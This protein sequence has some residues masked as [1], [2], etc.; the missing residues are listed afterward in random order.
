M[1]GS[2]SPEALAVELAAS[3]WRELGVP[4][5][6]RRHERWLITPEPLI[7]YTAALGERDRRLRD[8]ALGWCVAHLPLISTRALRN[9]HNQGRWRVAVTADFATT[10]KALTGARW[11]GHAVGGV[12]TTEAPHQGD[13]A[14]FEEPS[15]LALRLRAMFGVSV[16]TEVLR[17]LLS[18][19]KTRR[20]LDSLPHA[21][22][23]TGRQAAEAV[24]QLSWGGLVRLDRTVQPARLRLARR[25]ALQRLV[26]PLPAVAVDL[27][28]LL[29]LALMAVEVLDQI[30]ATPADL[31]GRHLH[32]VLEEHTDQLAQ[33]GLVPPGLQPATTYVSRTRRWL[34]EFLQSLSA[35]RPPG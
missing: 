3:L 23:A 35:G 21:A 28:A 32:R 29:P 27:G 34:R 30:S 11:P 24:E 19:D 18:A 14:P 31:A 5:P 10:M 4:G 25:E 7:L 9:T 22:M 33:V 15:Q 16:R 12:F 26:G 20:S 6:L 1:A 8:Q 17:V 2:R 13:A